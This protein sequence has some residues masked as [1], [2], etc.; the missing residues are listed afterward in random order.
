MSGLPTSKE[1]GRAVDV[2]VAGTGVA[3]RRQRR[4]IAVNALI[5]VLN[6]ADSRGIIPTFVV[7]GGFALELRFR[8]EARASRDVDIVVPVDADDMLDAL[9]EVLR[10]EWSAFRFQIKG[11]AER[12][13]HSFRLEVNAEYQ[14]R[15]WSTFEL[16]LVF[17]PVTS[18]DIV[19]PLDLASYGLLETSGI[20]CITI[21]EQIAQKM[22]AVTDPSENRPRD[23]IDIFLCLQRIDIDYDELRDA[24]VRVFD[25]RATHTWPPNIDIK[26]DWPI[27]LEGIIA[28]S[29]L[30]I[31]VDDVIAGARSLIAK[32]VG[33][34]M[35]Q[36]FRYHFLVLSAQQNVPNMLEA[37]IPNDQALETFNRMTQTEGW[38]LSHLL[39][40]PNRDQTRAMLA[41]LEKPI[42]E[43]Q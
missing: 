37:A 23:L 3:A 19:E 27:A 10:I 26:E 8:A 28:D 43:T 14:N 32:L 15:P 24:C 33:I 9:V 20:P 4:W 39:P 17:A 21:P 11:Q 12:R 18:R 2:R 30:E 16:E 5:E 13:E 31:T 29:S 40:Y 41:V 1:L 34:I 38:R 22:H 6:L 25:E 36:N 7:K 35:A 42:E